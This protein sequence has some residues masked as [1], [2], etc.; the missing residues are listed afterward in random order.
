MAHL[1]LAE[2]ARTQHHLDRVDLVISQVA[3]D[4]EAVV[5]PSFAERIGVVRESVAH[6][7]WLGVVVTDSQLIADIAADYDVVIMGGDKWAQLHE[8]R[9][10]ESETHMAESLAALPE[11]AIAPRDGVEIPTAALLSVEPWVIEI[12]SSGARAGRSEWMTPAA[13][14]SG[15]W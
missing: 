13:A 1:A 8:L 14:A 11:L 9:F 3:L 5:I 7:G 15:L 10:Y 4:K 12:S 6:S 2:A